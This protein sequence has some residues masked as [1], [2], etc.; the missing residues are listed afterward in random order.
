MSICLTLGSP[1]KAA[2]D[3]ETANEDVIIDGWVVLFK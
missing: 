1:Y 2:K 3:S